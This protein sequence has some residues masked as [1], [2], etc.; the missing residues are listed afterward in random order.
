MFRLQNIAEAGLMPMMPSPAAAPPLPSRAMSI[1]AQASSADPAAAPDAFWAALEEELALWR[2]E[3]R[4]AG[5]WWRD[6][7]AVAANPALERLLGLGEGAGAPVAVAAVP[8]LLEPSLA[9][10]LRGRAGAT[11]LQHG[12]AHVNHAK[13]R[14]EGAWELGPH[15]PRAEILAEL[16]AGRDM[17]RAAFGGQ[18]LPVIAAPWNRIDRDL[19][20]GLRAGG[21]IGIS[22]A[23]ERPPADAGAGFV[24]ANIHFDL[25]AWKAGRRFR[26]HAAAG[27]AILGHLRRRRLGRADPAEPTGILSHHLDLDEDAWS[28][29][30]ELLA[31]TARHPA[32]RWLSPREVFGGR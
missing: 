27:A 19:M 23:G 30:A 32:A 9:P 20:P 24:E 8:A 11:V 22:A 14:G 4:V 16:A 1:A 10:G 15:R 13:G 28:F 31:V 26:G 18:F 6:D 17:L 7:D 5:F 29:L 25:I 12:F 3:G 2:A 21:F